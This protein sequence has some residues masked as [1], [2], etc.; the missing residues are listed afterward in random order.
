MNLFRHAS[1]LVNR[2]YCRITRPSKC[3]IS[4]LI[5]SITFSFLAKSQ[6]SIFWVEDIEVWYIEELTIRSGANISTEIES[7]QH[8]D[9]SH[10]TFI[11]K[12]PSESCSEPVICR[13]KNCQN[14]TIFCGDLW[15][16]KDKYGKLVELRDWY[17]ND[18]PPYFGSKQLILK[19]RIQVI[20]ENRILLYSDVDLGQ[21]KINLQLRKLT[22]HEKD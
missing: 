7:S 19:L 13:I 17:L 21:G 11:L 6:S 15:F 9:P 20:G 22:V 10:P 8:S 1:S 14:E 4:F 18:L 16:R 5:L 12:I 2:T 3:C